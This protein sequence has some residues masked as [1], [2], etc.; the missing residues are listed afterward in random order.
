MMTTVLLLLWGTMDNLQRRRFLVK[1]L[2]MEAEKPTNKASKE[3][4]QVV[5]SALSNEIPENDVLNRLMEVLTDDEKTNPVKR[6]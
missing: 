6:G 4:V 5:E 3:L 1:L 2:E